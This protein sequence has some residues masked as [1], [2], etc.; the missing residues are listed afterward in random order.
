MLN[1]IENKMWKIT[2]SK[3]FEKMYRGTESKIHPH[4]LVNMRHSET[5]LKSA[6]N[7]LVNKSQSSPI[8][9]SEDMRSFFSDSPDLMDFF[10]A[11]LVLFAKEVKKRDVSSDLRN[12]NSI[13]FLKNQLATI[14]L[15]SDILKGL[16][17]DSSK[18]VL[19]SDMWFNVLMSTHRTIFQSFFRCLNMAFEKSYTPFSEKIVNSFKEA[20]SFP[21]I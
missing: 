6:L 9:T 10:C 19:I 7:E 17:I 21:Y 16:D 20:P 12:E 1:N 14:D 11:S 8:E 3:S 4:D 18:M 5:E 15:P 13:N 2:N